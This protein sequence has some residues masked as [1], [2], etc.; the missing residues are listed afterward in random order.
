MGCDSQVTGQEHTPPP[1]PHPCSQGP[2][3]HPQAAVRLGYLDVLSCCKAVALSLDWPAPMFQI[4][5]AISVSLNYNFCDRLVLRMRRKSRSQQFDRENL[6][7]VA[8]A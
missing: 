2:R 5:M 1:H 6:E 8:W 7:H 4:V 3:E